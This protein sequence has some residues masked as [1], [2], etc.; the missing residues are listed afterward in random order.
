MLSAV[1]LAFFGAIVALYWFF[2]VDNLT[3]GALRR[4]YELFDV[5]RQLCK[6]GCATNFRVK[7]GPSQD[8]QPGHDWLSILPASAANNSRLEP[9]QRFST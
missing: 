5:V 7:L 3:S 4:M 1:F 2:T 6:R 8:F 9:L